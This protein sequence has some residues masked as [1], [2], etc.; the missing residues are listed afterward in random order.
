MQEGDISVDLHIRQS[1]SSAE[2]QQSTKD[3]SK[4]MLCIRSVVLLM[5]SMQSPD[6][7]ILFL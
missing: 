2:L 7:S 4:C 6:Q 3:R 1:G 5:L